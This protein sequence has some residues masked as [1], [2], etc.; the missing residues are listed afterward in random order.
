MTGPAIQCYERSNLKLEQHDDD[1]GLFRVS[2]GSEVIDNLTYVRAAMLLGSCLMHQLAR[3]G[4]INNT[5][6]QDDD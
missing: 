5:G 4:L 1:H 2:Y 3:E 6:V